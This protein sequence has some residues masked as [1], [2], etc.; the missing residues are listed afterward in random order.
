[1]EKF[2]KN[3]S[4]VDNED[5]S[6]V[7]WNGS[8]KDHHIGQGAN[9]DGFSRSGGGVQKQSLPLVILDQKKVKAIS[10]CIIL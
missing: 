10:W 4:E 1:M 8:V 6:W 3:L 5:T 2:T 7:E 9:G